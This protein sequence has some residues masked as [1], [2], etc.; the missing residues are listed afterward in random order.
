MN[1]KL[2]AGFSRVSLELTS[3]HFFIAFWAPFRA[4]DTDFTT[5][6]CLLPHSAVQSPPATESFCFLAHNIISLSSAPLHMWFP[7]PGPVFLLTAVSNSHISLNPPVPSQRSGKLLW[8]LQLWVV[9]HHLLLEFSIF[10]P[11]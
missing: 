8:A 11:L 5:H 1:S 10:S 6:L 7:L 2:V 9:A 3:Y 4:L